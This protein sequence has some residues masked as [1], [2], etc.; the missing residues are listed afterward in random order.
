LG[1]KTERQEH[2]WERGIIMTL[3]MHLSDV[4]LECDVFL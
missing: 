3:M 1:T 4:M 2:G